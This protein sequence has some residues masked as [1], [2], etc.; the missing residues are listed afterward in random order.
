MNTTAT[1]AK[2]LAANTPTAQA[3]ATAAALEH[4][5]LRPPRRRVTLV[6]RIAL[7]IGV[8]LIVW[9]RAGRPQP[10]W[11]QIALQNAER[12]ARAQRERDAQ[13]RWAL[14][15]MGMPR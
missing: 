7:R 1:E 14:M 5:V 15:G 3:G 12:E 8:A 6:H 9:G 11:S 2:N 4:T 10:D 13:R